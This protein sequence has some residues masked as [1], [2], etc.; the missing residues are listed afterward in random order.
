MSQRPVV[1]VGDLGVD[2][3]VRAGAVPSR[4]GDT[5]S[6]IDQT[7]GGAGGNSA[8]WLA[9]Y[10]VPVVLVARV[11]DDPAGRLVRDDLERSGVSGVLAVDPTRPT[12]T[13]VS[14]VEPGG[15]RSMLSD[16]GA[17]GALVPGDID[18]DAALAAVPPGVLGVPH[19]HLSGF[20][21]L[22]ESSRAAGRYA[23]AE[24]RRR[25]W[26]TSVDP[27]A[28]NLV[29]KAGGSTFLEWV[30]GTD[31]LLPNAAE[32][33]AL[34]GIEAALASATEVVV[35]RGADGAGWVTR[36]EDW[37][38]RAERVEV[39]DTTGC[40][41]AFNAGLLAAWCA[42]AS[43]QYALRVGVGAGA[44]AASQVGSRPL[45]DG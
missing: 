35:T 37:S 25:G 16:R 13:V 41:D 9:A 14:V 18:L 4:G 40:G 3:V 15:E 28:S 19:L 27:Q 31:L 5:P 22:S 42:G 32:L 6:L 11:G 43:R 1:V 10:A 34:G 23:L 29:V 44:L 17:S 21:L 30:R 8:S 12:C 20:V 2:V 33:D 24:A 38:V 26:S 45:R 39:V 36:D 7:V